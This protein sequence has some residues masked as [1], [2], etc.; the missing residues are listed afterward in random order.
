MRTHFILIG[1]GIAS[2]LAA[3][4]LM[5]AG[6][7]VAHGADFR[8]DYDSLQTDTTSMTG[9]DYQMEAGLS[10]ITAVETAETV[11]DAVP[12]ESGD[13]S[14]GGGGGNST[15]S[16]NGG[17]RRQSV[18]S[19]TSVETPE[20]PVAVPV[21]VRPPR[22]TVAMSSARSVASAV[23]NPLHEAAPG[24]DTEDQQAFSSRFGGTGGHTGSS[25]ESGIASSPSDTSE[26]GKTGPSAADAVAL[27]GITMTQA[28]ILAHLAWIARI[29]SL[30][31][32]IPAFLS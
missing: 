22:H 5:M 14:Q 32:A 7:V 23:Q 17:G 13:G 15:D 3:A 21:P 24:G 12:Q 16:Q 4:V 30:Y 11:P 29:K 31:G 18:S 8:L 20:T 27:G 10:P 6:I 2:L 9:G 25:E 1:R 28:A 26:S 19:A